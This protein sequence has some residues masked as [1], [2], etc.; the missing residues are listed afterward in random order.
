MSKIVLTS[1]EFYLPEA[2]NLIHKNVPYVSLRCNPVANKDGKKGSAQYVEVQLR[3]EVGTQ[4]HKFVEDQI[5]LGYQAT[6]FCVVGTLQFSPFGYDMQQEFRIEKKVRT[7][8]R[9]TACGFEGGKLI[10]RNELV[11]TYTEQEMLHFAADGRI[12]RHTRREVLD[13]GHTKEFLVAAERAMVEKTDMK[14]NNAF[15]WKASGESKM[16]R[17]A[18]TSIAKWTK[19]QMRL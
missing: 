3:G 2:G 8:I 5:S 14:W 12:T 6:D 13:M 18:L 10:F 4:T 11:L 1:G 17:E 7:S 16:I 15:C 19:P 9:A